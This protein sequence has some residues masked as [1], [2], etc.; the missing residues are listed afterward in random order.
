M[1]CQK[2]KNGHYNLSLT[3]KEIDCIAKSIFY[4]EEIEK[5]QKEIQVLF[6][7]FIDFLLDIRNSFLQISD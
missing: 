1:K 6:K 2:R 4:I 5:K 7:G 3:K